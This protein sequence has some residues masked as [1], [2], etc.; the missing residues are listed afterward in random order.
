MFGFQLSRLSVYGNKLLS[1]VRDEPAVEYDRMLAIK[2]N[3]KYEYETE[4]LLGGSSETDSHIFLRLE[5]T[6]CR[7]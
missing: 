5:M 3:V 7:I 2:S 4:H 6:C 1:A